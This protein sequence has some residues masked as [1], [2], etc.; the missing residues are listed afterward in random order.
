MGEDSRGGTLEAW[1]TGVSV[2]VSCHRGPPVPDLDCVLVL[3]VLGREATQS[4]ECCSHTAPQVALKA[5]G[6]LIS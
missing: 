2:Q 5:P 1:C 6:T 4:E 3:V